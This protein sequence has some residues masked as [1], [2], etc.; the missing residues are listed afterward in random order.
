MN[1]MEN[2]K[3]FVTI[4]TKNEKELK[5]LRQTIRIYSQD[6]GMEFFMENE[7]N[8]ND[9]K[10]QKTNNGRNRTVLSIKNQNIWRKEKWEVLGNIG[11]G[12]HQ[13]SGEERKKKRR[14]E[15]LR[16]TRK[17]IETYLAS[18]ISLKG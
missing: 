10:R 6:I 13:T 3:L 18:G 5:I 11:S 14:K 4:T 16:R 1:H 12:H 8:E 7:C 2:I 9:E 17:I 15:Y